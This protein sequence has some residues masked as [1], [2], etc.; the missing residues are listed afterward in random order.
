[1]EV[2]I[3]VIKGAENGDDFRVRIDEMYGRRFVDIR[4]FAEVGQVHARHHVPTRKG[5]AIP[6]ELVP[7]VIEALQDGARKLSPVHASP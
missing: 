1:M 6:P 4:R 5:V 3:A 2:T 7:Q